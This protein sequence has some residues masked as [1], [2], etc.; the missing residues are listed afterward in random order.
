MQPFDVSVFASFKFAD[1]NDIN[2]C[3]N[4]DK[5]YTIYDVAECLV[6]AMNKKFTQSNIKLGVKTAE[7]YSFNSNIFDR[8]IF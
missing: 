2:G 7:I 3:I 4:I 1:N 5:R 6:N 8:E